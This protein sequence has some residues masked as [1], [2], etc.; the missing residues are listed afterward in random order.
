VRVISIGISPQ[1]QSLSREH[2]SS[3]PVLA[4]RSVPGVVLW[5]A[6]AVGAMTT[7]AGCGSDLHAKSSAT[8]A[9]RFITGAIVIETT[10]GTIHCDVETGAR[11]FEM[12]AH[13]NYD[14]RA[15][16]RTIPG[17][18]VQTGS[19]TDDGSNGS[20]PRVA[21]EIREDDAARLSKPGVLLL[22]RYTPPPNRVDPDPPKNGEVIGPQLVIGLADMS[23]LAGTVTVAGACRDLDVV[24]RISESR[25]ARVS[26][27]SVRR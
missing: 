18:L 3:S 11:A 19:P 22:A 26:R 6:A 23:H 8:S 21:I 27:A 16:F 14:G 12:I 9:K 17:V 4:G 20:Q 2:A 13:T 15:F 5:L 7:V 10:E 25:S 24:K 1:V